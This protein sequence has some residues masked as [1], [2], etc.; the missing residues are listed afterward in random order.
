MHLPLLQFLQ[1]STRQQMWVRMIE[2]C[3]VK[4]ALSFLAL[5]TGN[6]SFFPR[7]MDKPRLYLLQN[8]QAQIIYG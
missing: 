4:A 6:L 2:N 1:Y 3:I 8:N 5:S 7:I